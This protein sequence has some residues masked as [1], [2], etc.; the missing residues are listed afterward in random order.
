[1]S[2]IINFIIEN[3]MKNKSLLSSLLILVLLFASSFVHALSLNF[4]KRG[5]KSC[6]E[7]CGDQSICSLE[8]DSAFRWCL[9][10]CAYKMDVK[11]LCETV[12]P[13]KLRPV[14]PY[15]TYSGVY[16]TNQVSIFALEN[17]DRRFVEQTTDRRRV[18]GT[19]KL[20]LLVRAQLLKGVDIQKLSAPERENL[21][22]K[23]FIEYF[24][25][26]PSIIDA[27]KKTGIIP[28]DK[29]AYLFKEVKNEILLKVR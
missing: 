17:L 6:T 22:D 28:D 11:S 12:V 13:F 20:I 23:L 15:E 16:N 14:L 24:K 5:F 19:A 3:K 21:A 7:T 9:K 25:G 18:V 29:L 10:N 8:N 4:I 1:M 2:I 26:V 27:Y